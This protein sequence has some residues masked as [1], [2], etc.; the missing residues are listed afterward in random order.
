MYLCQW[1]GDEGRFFK[2]AFVFGYWSSG[3]DD[4]CERGDG[5][6]VGTDCGGSCKDGLNQFGGAVRGADG[7]IVVVASSGRMIRWWCK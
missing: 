3:K 6:G 2:F 4:G 5:G 1:D 7:I